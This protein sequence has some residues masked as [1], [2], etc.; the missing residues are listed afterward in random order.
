MI[1]PTHPYYAAPPL[2]PPLP[3]IACRGNICLMKSFF[4]GRGFC[5]S[6]VETI[7]MLTFALANFPKDK[8][9]GDRQARL[10]SELHDIRH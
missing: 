3:T 2:P 5:D 1:I 8:S 6:G 9:L 4:V 7:L 10:L